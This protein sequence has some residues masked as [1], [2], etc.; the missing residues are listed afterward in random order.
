[1]SGIKVV[2]Q[3]YSFGALVPKIPEYYLNNYHRLY[4]IDNQFVYQIIMIG[5]AGLIHYVVMSSW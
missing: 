5:N 3:W 1:L 4:P 2:S